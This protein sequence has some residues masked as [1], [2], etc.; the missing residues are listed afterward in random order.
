MALILLYPFT[1]KK[2]HILLSFQ[3]GELERACSIASCNLCLSAGQ[4]HIGALASAVPS[5][6]ENE[7]KFLR[8]KASVRMVVRDW[9]SSSFSSVI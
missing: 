2:I 3:T 1:E 6:E 9:N 4:D 5:L 7:H 8:G